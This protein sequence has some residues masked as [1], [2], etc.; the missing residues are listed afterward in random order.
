MTFQQSVANLLD[1]W[2][3][4]PD[5]GASIVEW[6]TLPARGPRCA[7]FPNDLHP[8]LK[9]SLR[10]LGIQALYTHQA[11]AWQ[12]AQEGG[13]MVV[14]TGTASGKTLCYNLPVLDRLLRDPQARALYIFP[15]KALA[16]DQRAGL[17][18]LIP[19]EDSELGIAIYDGDTPGRIRPAIRLGTRLLL[20]NPD[21][22]HMGILPHHTAWADFL[23]GLHYVVVDELHTYRGVFGS[24][25]ANVLRRLRRVARFYGAFPQFILTSATIANP[26]EL[27]NWLVEDTVSLIDDDGSGRGEKHFLIYN[28]PIVNEELGIRRG[29]LRETVG[30]AEDL[31]TYGVQ[32]VIFGRSRRTVE[33]ILA[34]LREQI[35]VSIT[36]EGSSLHREGLVRGYRSGYLPKQRREIEQGLRRGNVR[37]VVATSALELGVD[38]GGMGAALLAGYPGSVATTW[39]QAGRAGRNDAESLAV[40]ITGSEPLDQFLAHYPAYF[41]E[42]SPEQAL[43]DPNNLLILLGHVRCAAFELPFQAGES[44]GNLGADQL[45]E[46]LGYLESQ[47]VL[48][49]SGE[50]Y[51]WVADQ[52]PAQGISLRSASPDNVTL[53]V[54][55]GSYSL[56]DQSVTGEGEKPQ[57][58]GVVDIPSAVWMVHPGAIYLH[59]AQSYL[60]KELDLEQYIAH[61]TPCDVDYYTE[62]SRE[63]DAQ[64]IEQERNEKISGGWKGYGDLLITTRVVGYRK[65]RWQTHETL[66]VSELDLPPSELVTTGYWLSLDDYTIKSLQAQGLWSGSPNDYGPGWDKLRERVRARDGYRCQVCGALEQE[67]AHHVHHKIPFRAFA[68]TEQANQMHNLVTL[69][70]ACH[71]RAELAVRVRSGLSGLAFVLGNLAPLFVMC[72]V[73]DLGIHSDPA[74]PIANGRPSVVLYDMIPAGIG[75]SNRLYELHD[76]LMGRA[77]E[78]VE[79]CECLDGCP[80]CI[81]PGGFAITRGQVLVGESVLPGGKRE[82][83]AILECLTAKT[84]P[85]R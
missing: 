32:S 74:S 62:P 17:N 14:V 81:G 45:L 6:R 28:P 49:Y 29:V 18:N 9:D 24:H 69:C 23:R 46:F 40:L 34:H 65:I 85:D 13:N 21:M 33:V 73:G 39:Q 41:F 76:E 20:S 2:R 77:H 51:Y 72:D 70:A 54:E 50:K 79:A 12:R 44:Y 57:T 1:H 27:A 66:G 83:L 71:H 8:T 58:I 56:E 78:L 38:I 55:G 82:A 53:L 61:M 75:L 26:V 30:L 22:L 3:S 37:L 64:L 52:Y 11:Q 59:E 47:G 60:V 63:T 80:S 84:S 5:I 35:G 7:P 67:H 68:T 4:D 42:R 15:T 36:K 31:L 25:V 48:H 19:S 10:R 16:Q 43:V